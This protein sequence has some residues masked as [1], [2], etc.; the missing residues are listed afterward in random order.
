MFVIVPATFAGYTVT[1]DND[2]LSY[3]IK[4]P[5]GA[6]FISGVIHYFIILISHSA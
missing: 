5:L 2:G 6:F 4:A 1:K 3:N